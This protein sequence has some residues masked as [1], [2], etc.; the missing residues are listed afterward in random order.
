MD[1]KA[2]LLTEKEMD[3]NYLIKIFQKFKINKTLDVDYYKNA[4]E[5]YD[6]NNE[7]I[8][9]INYKIANLWNQKTNKI[10]ERS[11]IR[12]IHYI[13]LKYLDVIIKKMQE[14]LKNKYLYI[15]TDITSNVYDDNIINALKSN[16]FEGDEF[17]YF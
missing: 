15:Y 2:K 4:V 12:S 13:D 8:G 10:Y 1:I 7:L 16:N 6:E 14:I 3:F 11:F 9:F 5:I 17:V